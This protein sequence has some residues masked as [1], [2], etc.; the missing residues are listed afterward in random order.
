MSWSRRNSAV[1]LAA[2]LS[3][4]LLIGCQKPAAHP[5]AGGQPSPPDTAPPALIASTSSLKR[6]LVLPTLDTP[7]PEGKSAIW[8]SSFQLAWN[9]FERDFTHGPIQIRNAEETAARLNKAPQ[10]TADL[11][12]ED[13]LI[14]AG[15]VKAG[16]LDTIRREMRQRFPGNEPPKIDAP[17]EALIAF[18][19]LKAGVRYTYEFNDNPEPFKFTDSTGKTTGVHSFGLLPMS[20]NG[21]D[22][23]FARRLVALLYESGN[24]NKPWEF[25]VD[26]C[27]DSTP[28]QV[29]VACLKRKGTLAETLADL[30]AKIK[31]S[32]VSANYRLIEDELLVPNMSWR[33]EHRFKELEGTDKILLNGPSPG[34]YMAAAWQE[35]QF[36]LDRRG[37]EV[38]S[39]AYAIAMDGG[40]KKLYC[41]RPFLIFLK[42]RDDGQLFLVMWVDNAELMQTQEATA[43]KKRGT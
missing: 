21:P 39:S 9:I 33:I 5:R 6:T 15:S 41:D 13:Y 18:A 3:A 16:V 25:A 2:T 29:V 37:A 34:L 4:V 30:D 31:R 11:N 23:P 26:L 32:P 7:F 43:P 27:R 28:Y 12:A 35:I 14:A 19:F 17:P 36:K 1:A 22:A 38:K 42:K 24:Q 10:S 20:S 8:C 40:P